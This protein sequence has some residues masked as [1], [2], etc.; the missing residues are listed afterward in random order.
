MPTPRLPHLLLPVLL[1]ASPACFLD[2]TEAIPCEAGD[3]CPS[4]WDCD[5]RSFQCIEGT[6]D[7][8]LLPDDTP[9]AGLPSSDAGGGEDA[10][11]G[12]CPGVGMIHLTDVPGTPAFCVDAYEA[13]RPDA[14][15][16]EPGLDTSAST[17]QSGVH[18][19]NNADANGAQRACEGAGKRLCSLAEWRAA[20]DNGAGTLYPYGNTFASGVCNNFGQIG[21]A[22]Q[23]SGCTGPAR[24]FDMSG[25]LAEIVQTPAGFGLVGGHYDDLTPEALACNVQP[26]D[27]TPAPTTGFRCCADP[28]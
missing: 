1:L 9:D 11:A 21:A 24:T 2:Y 15:R 12:P 8:D 16:A 23:F 13:S 22:G 20:C 10:P 6:F 4:G 5:L 3:Q 19:W 25:N 14:T 27:V 26:L 7:P 17:S 18:P 28:R